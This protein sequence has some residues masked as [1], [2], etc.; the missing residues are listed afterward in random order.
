MVLRLHV[1]C[2][3]S[4]R[5]QYSTRL[6][7][8][9]ESKYWVSRP[10]HHQ[11]KQKKT[12]TSLWPERRVRFLWRRLMRWE[13]SA[14]GPNRKPRV[15]ASLRSAFY[16]SEIVHTCAHS[17][18]GTPWR[19]CGAVSKWRLR[20]VLKNAPL[21]RCP[22]PARTTKVHSGS[23]PSDWSESPASTAMT[24]RRWLEFLEFKPRQKI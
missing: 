24:G 17:S 12:K 4:L 2:S 7:R 8:S 11:K 20:E 23:G 22:I 1:E 10:L 16:R 6:L 9:I 3:L 15:K 19:P 18:L 14:D 13:S 21:T 5:G